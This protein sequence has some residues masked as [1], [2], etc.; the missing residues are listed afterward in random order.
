MLEKWKASSTVE[1]IG[2]VGLL[3]TMIAIL[4]VCAIEIF[5]ENG[6]PFFAIPSLCCADMAFAAMTNWRNQRKLA[7]FNIIVGIFVLI[8]GIIVAFLQ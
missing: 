1:K 4:V 5:S 7:I 3:V 8:C 6:A 2:T